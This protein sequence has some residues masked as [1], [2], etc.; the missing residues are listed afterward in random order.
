MIKFRKLLNN[1]Y[2]NIMSLNCVLHT[3][4]S[5]VRDICTHPDVEPSIKNDC[6]LI[7]YFNNSTIWTR[8]LKDN[9]PSHI[10]HKLET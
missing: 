4:S 3:L 7:A 9:K 8:Y 10:K 6:Q 1:Q 5:L 2:N